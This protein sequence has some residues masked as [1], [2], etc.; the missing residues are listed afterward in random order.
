[1]KSHT[2][3]LTFH[4]PAR[5]GFVNITPQVEEAVRKSGVKEGLVLCNTMHITA[6]VFINDDERGLHHDF[7]KWLE[8]LASNCVKTGTRVHHI[9]NN[10]PTGMAGPD[11]EARKAGI[12]VA[13]KWLD[14]AAI[15]GAKSASGTATN[16]ASGLGLR[17]ARDTNG[18][19]NTR[20]ASAS[21][22]SAAVTCST[23]RWSPRLR[24]GKAS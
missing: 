24:R 19:S 17:R 7:G 1:M 9:S 10:A 21:S 8:Q 3:Y 6:S 11:E 22:E 4:I 23:G 5:V 16:S 20:C 18:T 12:E 14:G 2:E 13:K 15:I